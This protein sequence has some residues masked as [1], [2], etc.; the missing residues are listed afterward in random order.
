MNKIID[1]IIASLFILGL[2][3]TLFRIN[4]PW[5]MI[6]VDIAGITWS[7]IRYRQSHRG[8]LIA[9][10]VVLLIQLVFQ[11]ITILEAV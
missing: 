11:I 8:I 3:M 2:V 10:G 1:W 9:L 6:V 4:N 5:F 7:V